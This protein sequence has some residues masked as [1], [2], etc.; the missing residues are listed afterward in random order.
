LPSH[1]TRR[2]QNNFVSQGSCV[3]EIA[4]M[5][6]RYAPAHTTEVVMPS[7]R[8]RAAQLLGFSLI[9]ME[10]KHER[11]NH[12]DGR[13]ATVRVDGGKETGPA[14]AVQD[15][16]PTWNFYLRNLANFARRPMNRDL[17]AL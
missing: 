10:G 9:H 15:R 13:T 1:E 3:A 4:A 2:L 6:G 11:G 14:V 16:P 17:I 12:P 7:A 5:P 8:A